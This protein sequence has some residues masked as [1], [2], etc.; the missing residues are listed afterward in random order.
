MYVRLKKKRPPSVKFSK[1]KEPQV[2]LSEV[3]I[4]KI[5]RTKHKRRENKKENKVKGNRLIKSALFF[6]TASQITSKSLYRILLYIIDVASRF[7]KK[8]MGL[9]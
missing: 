9:F 8:Q 4:L 1:N 7:P 2:L 6:L 5:S 3:P